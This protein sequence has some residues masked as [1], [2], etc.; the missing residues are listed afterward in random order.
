MHRGEGD[1]GV[2]KVREHAS[3][4][5]SQFSPVGVIF[6]SRHELSEHINSSRRKLVNSVSYF[7]KRTSSSQVTIEFGHNPPKK[8]R[9]LGYSRS[10]FSIWKGIVQNWHLG[11][12]GGQYFHNFRDID[13]WFFA[14]FIISA[15]LTYS[16]LTKLTLPP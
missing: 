5:R 7:F 4:A 15:Q 8:E 16:G 1:P 13:F 11:G 9:I 14:K 12:G 6:Q 10:D 3:I 2:Q